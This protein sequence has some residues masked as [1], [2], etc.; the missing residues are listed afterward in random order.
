[1]IKIQD[2]EDEAATEDNPVE[3][4]LSAN[5]ENTDPD[6]LYELIKDLV[7]NSGMNLTVRQI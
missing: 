1:M 6:A 2:W 4:Y 5:P 3:Y 7:D